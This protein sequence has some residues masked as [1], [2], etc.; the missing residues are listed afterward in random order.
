VACVKIKIHEGEIERVTLD[1]CPPCQ[2]ASPAECDSVNH[3]V[4]PPEETRHVVGFQLNFRITSGMGKCF[5]AREGRTRI[6]ARIIRGDSAIPRI[7]KYVR[8]KSG[9]Q[10][11]DGEGALRGAIEGGSE[12]GCGVVASTSGRSAR[13]ENP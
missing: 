11:R 7:P 4:F 12:G 2:A 6:R 10:S 1:T 13:T 5:A 8:R 9:E 3:D